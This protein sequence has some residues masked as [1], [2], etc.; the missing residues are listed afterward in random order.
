VQPLVYGA[1]QREEEDDDE[2]SRNAA[3]T[4][5]TSVVE[6]SPKRSRLQRRK[7][8]YIKNTHA[9]LRVSLAFSNKDQAVAGA[10][11]VLDPGG[12]V[13]DSSTDVYRC[14]NGAITAISTAAGA[15]LAVFER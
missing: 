11:V 4:V 15:T 9:T 3:I 7:T 2:G 12:E 6:I 14:W 10:G 13:F 1:G 8:I 5:G